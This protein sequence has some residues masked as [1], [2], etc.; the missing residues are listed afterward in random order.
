MQ[1]INVVPV[2]K[3]RMTKQGK[4]KPAAMRYYAY[5][6]HLRASRMKVPECCYHLIFVLPMPKS[7]SKKKRAAMRGTRHQQVPDKDNLEK[8]CL[9]ALYGDDSCVWDGRVSKLWGDAGR[10]MV[11]VMGDAGDSADVVHELE[12]LGVSG[13]DMARLLM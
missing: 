9:D 4:F 12:A 7:W 6:N 8:A 11:R 13:E 2:A 3:P 1:I 10:V 5:A